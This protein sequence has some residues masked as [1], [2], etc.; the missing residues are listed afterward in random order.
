MVTRVGESEH[1]MKMLEERNRREREQEQ[2]E[3]ERNEKLKNNNFLRE[4]KRR[5]QQNVAYIQLLSE[6]VKDLVEI[7]RG[8]IHDA[9]EYDAVVK[10]VLQ[11]SLGLLK[12]FESP[13]PEPGKVIET[14]SPNRAIAFDDEEN[15]TGPHTEAPLPGIIGNDATQL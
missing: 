2:K 12:V 8:Q 9:A 14:E 10:A 4:E 1:E 3:F 11:N 6:T 5:N 13:L 15:G 7:N